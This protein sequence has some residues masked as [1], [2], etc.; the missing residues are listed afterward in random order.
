MAFEL[1]TETVEKIDKLIPRYPEKR[2][3]I[4]MILHAI[5]EE[6]RHVSREAMEWVAQRLELEPIQVY[7]VVSF[8]PMF[9]DKPTG[10]KHIK[11]CRTLSC[12]LQGAYKVAS[13]FEEKLGCGINATT[14]DGAFT[15]EFV[16]CLANCHNAPV[17][18]VG[19]RMYNKV[20]S[21][22]AEQ[23]A[24]DLRAEREAASAELPGKG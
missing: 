24:K 21:E 13:T 17:V 9:T 5:Q 6:Q 12:A 22:K 10:R 1:K 7:E 2:S 8:Y 4:L 3:A 20:T 18:Q 15:I 23:M 14:E 16:E 19:E 11:V